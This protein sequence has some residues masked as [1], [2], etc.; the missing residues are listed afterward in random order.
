MSIVQKFKKI[1]ELQNAFF[2]KKINE[3]FDFILTELKKPNSQLTNEEIYL[4]DK[5]RFLK[6]N[7]GL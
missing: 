1:I 6:Y 2:D 5:L 4:H 7:C 3:F